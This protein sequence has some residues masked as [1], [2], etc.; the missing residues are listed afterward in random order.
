MGNLDPVL[1]STGTP[2]KIEEELVRI[3]SSCSKFDNFM[4][5][6]GCDIPANA[7][8]DNLDTYFKKVNEFYA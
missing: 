5:S 3:F 7:K 1:F 4:I 8:I 2:E 6:S